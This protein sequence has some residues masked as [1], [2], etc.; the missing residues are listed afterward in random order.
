METPTRARRRRSK[1]SADVP[2][3]SVDYRHLT[4]SLPLAEGYSA[5]LGSNPSP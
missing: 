3:R 4:S 5:S 1:A 2:S